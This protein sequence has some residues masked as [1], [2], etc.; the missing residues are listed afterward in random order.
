MQMIKHV[1]DN[2]NCKIDVNAT[3]KSVRTAL[4]IHLHVGNPAD[5]VHKEKRRNTFMIVA[6]LMATIAFQA[7]VNP[8]G[9]DSVVSGNETQAWR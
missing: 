7:G 9:G 8:P 1:L 2:N 6:S 4:D 5:S 3:N